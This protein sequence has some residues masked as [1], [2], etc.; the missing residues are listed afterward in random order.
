MFHRG[1]LSSKQN[2]AKNGKRKV[3]K[4]NRLLKNKDNNDIK[5]NQTK[6]G[7]WTLTTQTA[8]KEP[9]RRHKKQ[10]RS[11]SHTSE[12]YENSKLEAI[13]YTYS[14]RTMYRTMQVLWIS[15]LSLWVDMK[16]DPTCSEIFIYMVSSILSVSFTI[17]TFSS[18]WFPESFEGRNLIETSHLVLSVP[19]SLSLCVC[20][21]FGCG[22]L[23][24]SHPL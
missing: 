19:R 3:K 24:F 11:I 1:N 18:V 5:S 10:R 14:Q 23:Y 13:I 22:C 17:F 4:R 7:Q 15:L 9:R 8:R 12:S 16:L 21:I 20:I 2:K 6:V